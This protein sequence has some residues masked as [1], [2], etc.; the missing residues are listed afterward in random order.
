MGAAHRG[1]DVRRKDFCQVC[2]SCRPIF[3]AE[4]FAQIMCK[5]ESFLR[6]VLLQPIR[7]FTDGWMGRGVQTLYIT[8][9]YCTIHN[10]NFVYYG[11]AL[12]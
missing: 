3:R 12:I 4:A 6:S 7:A 8:C 10:Q 2:V 1:G 5:A 9:A 11:V